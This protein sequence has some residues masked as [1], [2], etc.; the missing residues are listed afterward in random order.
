MRDVDIERLSP[1]ERARIRKERLKWR[2]R[3]VRHG[4]KPVCAEVRG[5]EKEWWGIEYQVP[6]PVIE[7]EEKRGSEVAVGEE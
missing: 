3:E 7:E 5:R 4:L 2:R 6:K 1:K